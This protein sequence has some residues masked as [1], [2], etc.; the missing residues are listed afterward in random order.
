MILIIPKIKYQE[1]IL[2]IKNVVKVTKGQKKLTFQ[3]IIILGDT[4]NKVGFGVGKAKDLSIA[5]EKA[6]RN[7]INN[8]LTININ[9]SFSISST[10]R[11]T[12]GA[13]EIIL[14]PAKLGTVIKAGGTLRTI[15]ELAGIKNIFTK[16]IGSSNRLNNVKATFLALNL[17]NK[18]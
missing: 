6:V 7:A 11:Q 8:L 5:N 4:I 13:S 2:Q 14:R 3:V 12:F 16:Q 15:L 9:S 10:I 17:L 1:R 18:K